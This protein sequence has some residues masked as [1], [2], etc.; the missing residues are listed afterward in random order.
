MQHYTKTFEADY[1]GI[2]WIDCQHKN[3]A[4]DSMR[5]TFQQL[6]QVYRITL[7][8]T[9]PLDIAQ[10]VKSLVARKPLKSFV[11]IFDGINPD[12]DKGI[13]PVLNQY[14]PESSNV[15]TVITTRHCGVLSSH[16]AQ[17]YVDAMEEEEA[18]Q[19]FYSTSQLD[20]TASLERV[21][22]IL[23]ALGRNA[24]ALVTAGR[25]VAQNPHVASSLNAHLEDYQETVEKKTQE[26]NSLRPLGDGKI[27]LAWQISFD[28][29]QRTDP[30]AAQLLLILAFL[31][32]E[33]LDVRLF[34]HNPGLRPG[35]PSLLPR[36]PL[37]GDVAKLSDSPMDIDRAFKILQ[38]YSLLSEANEDHTYRMHPL[39]RSW[40]LK[41]IQKRDRVCW[42]VFTA[43][44]LLEQA[45]CSSLPPIRLKEHA[46]KV[47]NDLN[48]CS[49]QLSSDDMLAARVPYVLSDLNDI[50]FSPPMTSCD[51]RIEKSSNSCGQHSCDCNRESQDLSSHYHTFSPS[52]LG[53]ISE[54]CT[55]LNRSK[56][57]KIVV[58]VEKPMK[59]LS[60]RPS[61]GPDTRPDQTRRK[62]LHQVYIEKR[63]KLGIPDPKTIRALERLAECTLE[64]GN[65]EQSSRY[66]D[67]ACEAREKFQG[68]YEKSTIRAKQNYVEH[69]LRAG[70]DEDSLRIR[71]Q[72]LVAQQHTFGSDHKA[73]IQTQR[74]LTMRASQLGYHDQ[75]QKYRRQVSSRVRSEHS[76]DHRFR[77]LVHHV[78]L[79]PALKKFEDGDKRHRTT[80]SRTSKFFRTWSDKFDNFWSAHT[81]GISSQWVS[82]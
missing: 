23:G 60:K 40:I 10:A 44:I 73:T 24:L 12:L 54:P 14:L 3:R 34:E 65:P 58:A 25:H 27:F 64:E 35:G 67:E 29:V 55:N 71:K 82:G 13:S 30:Q 37:S 56:L 9:T 74:D 61:F 70:K 53:N 46:E 28:H 32:S 49:R 5:H 79:P 17:I 20:D 19:L 78:I 11:F 59:R 80:F 22:Y 75:A 4:D 7:A 69:L 33:N 42:N 50:L 63:R 72:V 1:D 6:C 38:D 41:Q 47:A 48:D 66:L 8:P 45:R 16:T 77:H 43:T 2:F 51:L 68:P 21:S 62:A 18:A 39:L 31:D 15:H 76:E 36:S 57:D 52:R 26:S 81:D